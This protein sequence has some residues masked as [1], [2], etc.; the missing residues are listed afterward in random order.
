MSSSK[1]Q[2]GELRRSPLMELDDRGGESGGLGGRRAP[3]PCPPP[4]ILG[5]GELSPGNRLAVP[6]PAHFVKPHQRVSAALTRHPSSATP[7]LLLLWAIPAFVLAQR[8]AEAAPAAAGRA[9]GAA[10]PPVTWRLCPG[11]E[12]GALISLPAGTGTP[13]VVLRLSRPLAGS[14]LAT[15]P[16]LGPKGGDLLLVRLKVPVGARPGHYDGLLTVRRG[17]ELARRPATIEVLPFELMRP[18]K[19]YVVSR[20]PVGTSECRAPEDAD[21]APLRQLHDLGIGGLCLTAPPADR[22]AIESMMREA[23][24]HGPVLAPLP[25]AGASRQAPGDSSVPT[26]PRQV[27]RPGTREAG[28]GHPSPSGPAI[29]WYVYC[30]AL[31]SAETIAALRADGVLVACRLGD[32]SA[33]VGVDLPIFDADGASSERLLRDGRAAGTAGWWRWDAGASTP[34]ENRLRCGAW[35]WKNGLSGALVEISPD[36]PTATDWPLRW[37]GVRQGILDS[38]F[39]TTFFALMRQVKDMDRSSPQPRLAEAAVTAALKRVEDH[40]SAEAADQMRAVVIAWI[41]RLGRMVWS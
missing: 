34:L 24:L 32:K 17:R 16:V 38:R 12:E 4:P 11:T 9:P 40:P 33:A 41:L 25:P 27:T 31:P 19:Q 39:L 6:I 23:G 35:L 37:E 5:E 1:G 26:S 29:R 10:G 18:S 22:T 15:E 8:G 3:T 30:E 13:A 28:D 20:V 14:H 21:A 7:R 2:R 36:A